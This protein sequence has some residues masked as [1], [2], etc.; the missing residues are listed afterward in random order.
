MNDAVIHEIRLAGQHNDAHFQFH[1]ET[2]ALVGA[3]DAAA[4]HIDDGLPQ[5][6]AAQLAEL[7]EAL[8]KILKS[9]ITA[10]IHEADKKR[11]EAYKGLAAFNKAMLLHSDRTIRAAAERVQIVID[12]YGNVVNKSYEEESSA[13]YNLV[14][15][16]ASPKYAPD[17]EAAGLTQWV[18]KLGAANDRVAS[19]IA[20]RDNETAAKSH[21]NTK[22]AR[23]AIDRTYK[24]IASRVNS[25]AGEDATPAI[26]NFVNKMNIIVKRFNTLLKQQQS[27]HHHHHGGKDGETGE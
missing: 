16:L 20:V 5:R 1:S 6:H 26:E 2:A 13:V 11:D 7:D 9:P 3:S 10:Q 24:K 17:A 19:L 27:H 12:T 4:L 25:H 14:Q 18:S 21:V 22:A 8:K 23:T 15:D